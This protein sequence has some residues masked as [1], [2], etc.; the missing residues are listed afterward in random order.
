MQ[1]E[2]WTENGL[3]QGSCVAELEPVLDVF[4]ENFKI[5]GEVGADLCV[6]QGEQTLLDLRGGYR[7]TK[8]R[9]PWQA[10]SLCV[11]HSC[12]KGATALCAHWLL[13]QGD[14]LLHEPVA[15]YWPEFAQNGKDSVTVAMLLNH[16]AGL[17]A[18]RASLKPGG[19]LD[20]HYMVEQLA[21][22]APFWEPG[23]R[24]GYH[25]TTFGWLVGEVVRRVSG[26]SLGDFF[27]THIAE[28]LAVDLWIGLPASEHGRVSRL[29]R[30]K[31]EKGFQHAPFTRQLLAAP[32][33]IQALA[34]FNNG[35]YKADSADSYLCEFG[36]GG[37][38]GNGRALAR[39]YAPIAN[40]GVFN[41]V[42]VFSEDQIEIM[43]TTVSAGGQDMTLLMPSRFGYGFMKSMDN[44]YRPSGHIES[45]ILGANAL[46]H[47][48]A[49]GSLGFADPDLGL[50]FGYVMNK[51]GPGILLNERS[52]NLVNATYKSMGYRFSNSGSWV[53][54]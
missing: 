30:W 26:L 40:K 52:Q 4:V 37:G 6:M 10:D 39:M 35:G 17:P 7:S 48:G 46:G 43:A 54:A 15:T 45:C 5:R 24:H 13:D 44:R 50:S 2:I 19:Y 9:I 28:P 36:A 41:G 8:E 16:T 21:A 25:M 33:S 11:L 47:A 23:T 29:L 32:K 22:E 31:P 51:M 20:W 27:R 38:I 3:I 12:T 14:I 18:L 53:K 34:Y 1:R 49:G 42:R